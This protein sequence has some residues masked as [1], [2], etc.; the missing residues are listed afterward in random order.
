MKH[1]KPCSLICACSVLLSC[2][3]TFALNVSAATEPQN[4]SRVAADDTK[5]AGLIRTYSLVISA[6]ARTVN[7]T[8]ATY[9]YETMAKIGFTNIEVQRSTNGTS[10]WTAELTPI[11]DTVTNAESHTKNNEARSVV[12]GY[13]YRVKLDHYAKETGWIFPSSQSITNYSNAVWVPKS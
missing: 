6:S 4:T 12:G 13:Y 9:G 7:I 5:A 1:K 3:F 2:C 8:A 11:D 10:G